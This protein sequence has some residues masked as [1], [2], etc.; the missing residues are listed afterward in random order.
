MESSIFF[1]IIKCFKI[2]FLTQIYDLK[3]IKFI[4]NLIIF[5]MCLYVFLKFYILL[6]HFKLNF[7]LFF[8]I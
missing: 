6:V 4:L 1:I 2:L 8:S 5:Y 3:L 7:V